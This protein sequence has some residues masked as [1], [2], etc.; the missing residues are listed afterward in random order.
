MGDSTNWKCVKRRG[1]QII[2]LVFLCIR[3]RLDSEY[4]HIINVDKSVCV[5]LCFF[6]LAHLVTLKTC[7]TRY[8]DT[9]CD[10]FT[11]TRLGVRLCAYFVDIHRIVSL[12]FFHKDGDD[13]HSNSSERTGIKPTFMPINRMSTP[14]LHKVWFSEVKRL[15]KCSVASREI[16]DY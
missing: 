3:F 14:E 1:N 5:C 13:F 9:N 2:L 12:K 7:G 8:C 11:S 10:L 4:S 15:P 16:H 6:T